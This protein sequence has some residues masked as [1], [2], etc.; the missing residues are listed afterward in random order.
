MPD[1]PIFCVCVRESGDKYARLLS[2]LLKLYVSPVP[3]CV[4]TRGDICSI[5]LYV[6]EYR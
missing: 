6:A 4:A 1:G 2:V 3:R 5:E